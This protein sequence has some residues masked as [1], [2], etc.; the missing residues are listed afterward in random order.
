MSRVREIQRPDPELLL[1]Q[2]QAEEEFSCRG[3]L[4]V[5]LGYASGVGK[6]SRMLDEGRRR[7]ERGQDIVVGAIQPVNDPETQRLLDKLEVIPLKLHNG[8]PVM[9][10]EAILRRRPQVCI[11]DGLAYDNPPGSPN[12]K[13]WQDVEQLRAS[14]ISIIGSVNLQY[15]EDL[16][17]Q[18]E[19]ISGKRVS[20]TIPA[21]FLKTA[22]EIV[23]VDAPPE[24]C[25]QHGG[26]DACLGNR[27]AELREIALLLAADVVDQ[28]LES[29]LRRNGLELHWGAQERILVCITARANAA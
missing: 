27:L 3:R 13:R 15:I 7:R 1:R 17:E 9:D 24:F 19:K 12:P 23:I 20:Q 4:K 29:Y 14:G 11:V 2:V 5:F 25:I 10:V 28:Q 16:R 6:S 18:V 22:D 26:D 8:A 21:A